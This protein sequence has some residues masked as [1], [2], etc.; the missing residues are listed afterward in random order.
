MISLPFMFGL[1]LLKCMIKRKKDIKVE[2]YELLIKGLNDENYTNIFLS[3]M[4]V[5]LNGFDII[6]DCIDEKIIEIENSVLK[7]NTTKEK[8][9]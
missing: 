4:N 3:K 7:Q 1:F 6:N 9:L 8:Y 5:F 2:D